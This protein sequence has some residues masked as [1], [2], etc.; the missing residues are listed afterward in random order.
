MA[1][2]WTNII[3]GGDQT[4][5]GPN[6]LDGSF[7]ATA[8]ALGG[9]QPFGIMDGS[10]D[11]LTWERL[12]NANMWKTSA[13]GTPTSATAALVA[14]T[15][16]NP[17]TF[18]IGT[19]TAATA[20]NQIQ[21]SDGSTSNAQARFFPRAGYV[22]HMFTR[23]Q[24]ST[25]GFAFLLGLTEV[26]TGVLAT[27]GAVA[28]TDGIFLYKNNALADINLIIRRGGA[29][30]STT[31]G[32]LQAN[33]D[34]NWHSFGM[35]LDTTWADIW[36]DGIRTG[37][38]LSAGSLQPNAALCVSAAAVTSSASNRVLSLQGTC[39]FQEAR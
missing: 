35:R 21:S 5:N 2:N 14:P 8:Q 7:P 33:V 13:I 29:S 38:D 15:S 36:I 34:T 10:S 11:G 32:L 27:S 37:I 23:F 18:Q 24:L 12:A 16:T 1:Y 3:C 17:L 28:A 9:V 25:T 30:T 6:P 31:A 39:A 22:I 20:G 4:A 26:N 19:G